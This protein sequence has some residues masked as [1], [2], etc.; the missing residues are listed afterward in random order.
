MRRILTILVS[1]M[2]VAV[3]VATLL[4][5]LGAHWWFFDLFSHFR[6]QYFVILCVCTA[7][8]LAFRFKLASAVFAVFLVINLALVLPL[9]IGTNQCEG[10][11]LHSFSALLMNVYTANTDFQATLNLVVELDPDMVV[12]E[13]VNAAWVGQLGQ[14]KEAYPH[15]LVQEREDNFGIGV[16]SKFPLRG[17]EILHLGSAGVPTVKAEVELGSTVLTVIGT[18]PLPPVRSRYWRSRNEQLSGL[19]SLVQSVTSP[20]VVLGD[21]NTSPWS[22]HFQRLLNETNLQSAF[23]GR[24]FHPTWPTWNPVFYIPLDHCLHSPDV[25]V[26]RAQ[27][28]RAVASDHLPVYVVLGLPAGLN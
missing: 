25:C 19:S 11:T 28:A 7:V 27:V 3:S 23:T 2:A 17:A 1:L 22:P 13:E 18:H 15:S 4:G 21:L 14:L 5:L 16:L 9:F 24:G 6:V 20:V 10:Q 8:L 26:L 12:L